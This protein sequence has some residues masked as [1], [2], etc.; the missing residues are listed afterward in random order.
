MRGFGTVVTGTLTGGVL[1]MGD[2]VEVVPDGPVTRIRGL[3]VHGEAADEAPPGC[4]V[5]LNLGGV[6][7]G[8]LSRGQVLALAGTLHPA[9]IL[10][11][12]V[13]VL[14]D[15]ASP[16]V[17]LMRVRLHI[18][19]AEV[20][21]RFRPLGPEALARGATGAGQ[22][23]LERPVAAQ[24]GDHFVLRRYSPLATLAGGRVVDLDPPKAR[25][26]DRRAADRARRL[27][28]ASPRERALILAAEAEEA[29]WQGRS[30]SCRLGVPPAGA[31]ALLDGLVEEGLLVTAGERLLAPE[32]RERLAEAVLAGI[33]GFHAQQP[34]E[35]GI[36]REVLRSVV[37][38]RLP[39]EAFRGLLRAL[40]EQ[41]RVR[42]RGDAVADPGHRPERTAAQEAYCQGVE[43]R[44]LEAGL[45]PPSEDVLLGGAPTPEVGRRLLRLLER[46][47]RLVRLGDGRYFHA[48][49]LQHLRERLRERARR[50]ED[51]LDVA[52]FKK[53][54]GVTRKSAIPLL[55]RF[56]AERLTVRRGDL[57]VI[58]RG[59]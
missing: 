9:S 32:A 10:D 30:Q 49:P 57:R 28:Q 1:R 3:E 33:R 24:P 37:A 29:G 35:D 56:D 41:G 45:D 14:P 6:S 34:L 50:G 12:V 21:A 19:T 52:T 22:L 20:M 27:G 23:R 59:S 26:G 18:G 2:D 16:L 13:E 53:L 42:L 46:E 5:A 15:A 58:L 11:A 38:P 8:S 40:E 51:T 4:R 44:L 54:A 17:D 48:A 55:E 39:A 7:K 47:G 25:R 43:E 36:L 31:A